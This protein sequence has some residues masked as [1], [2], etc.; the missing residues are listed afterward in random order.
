MKQKL[1][2]IVT[3]SIVLLIGICII[4]KTP[5]NKNINRR[6][7]ANIYEDGLVIGQTTIVID[8]EK[9]NYLFRKT[10]K[11]SG[12]FLIPY[13]EK[14][15]RSELLT[16]ITWNGE[17]NTQR[18]GYFYKGSMK[19]A[20]DMGLVPVLLINDSM[21]RFAIMLTDHK[22]IATSK[23]LYDL[24]TNHITWHDDNK[25]VVYVERATEIP[26]ID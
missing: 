21:T 25:F 10:D 22:V 6:I 13:A 20:Q 18:I 24:Y 4:D 17:D 5:F 11:F 8:G 7:I 16:Y 1:K 15:D 14:T 23:E 26:Q 19:L 3:I 2:T 12:V 9:S